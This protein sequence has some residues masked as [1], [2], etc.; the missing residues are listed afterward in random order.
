MHSVYIIKGIYS[1]KVGENESQS[2]LPCFYKL[3]TFGVVSLDNGLKASLASCSIILKWK[4]I[5]EG[6]EFKSKV[7]IFKVG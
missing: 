2:L 4:N 6:K 1:Y 5:E 3:K 7:N